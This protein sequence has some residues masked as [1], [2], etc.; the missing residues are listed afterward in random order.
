[1]VGLRHEIIHCEIGEENMGDKRFIAVK[2]YKSAEEYLLERIAFLECQN[3][4]LCSQLYNHSKVNPRDSNK[5]DEEKLAE[6]NNRLD[7][8][9]KWLD[10]L[11]ETILLM[12]YKYCNKNEDTIKS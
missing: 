2:H 12:N 11:D 7:S 8:L 10:Q 4:L 1:M 9:E 5:S 6:F 3:E